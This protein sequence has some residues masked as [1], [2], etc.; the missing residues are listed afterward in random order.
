M[1]VILL[2]KI[3]N[4]GEL[5]DKVEVKAGYARNLLIPEGKAAPATKENLEKFAARR[6]EL[7]EKAKESL[8]IAQ[9][10]AENLQ[11]LTVTI[12]MQASE[13]GKLF[14]SVGNREIAAAY[15][16]AGE[17]LEKSEVILSEGPIR[18]LGDHEIKLQLHSDVSIVTT[19]K[20]VAE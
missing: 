13:E 16:A 10:R 12:P 3:R 18:E 2:E 7:E 9:G 20:V 17:T 14:G 19:I 6:A 15:N 11:K 4:L 5:G 1:Q 8:T